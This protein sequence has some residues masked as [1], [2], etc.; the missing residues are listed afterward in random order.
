PLP[1]SGP[2]ARTF[3]KMA[4]DQRRRKVVLFGGYDGSHFVNDT[5]ELGSDLD[6][7]TDPAR[8]GVISGGHA[9]LRV[10]AGG[11]GPFNYQWLKN[12]APISDGGGVSGSATDTLI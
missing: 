2:S 9:E 3:V 11:T 4:Y 10:V 8:Q 12:G 7:V 5:W 1:V 6:V